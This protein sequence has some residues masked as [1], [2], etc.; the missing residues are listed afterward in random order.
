MTPEEGLK[1]M[2]DLVARCGRDPEDEHIDADD[3]L[4]CVLEGYGHGKLVE[5]FKL[6]PKW[7]A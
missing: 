2:S 4:C 6:L 7:Y 3:I 5:L 1:A